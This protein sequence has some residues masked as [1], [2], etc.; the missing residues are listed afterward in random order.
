MARC[1]TRR[2]KNKKK[3]RHKGTIRPEKKPHSFLH[4]R[5]RQI[6][7]SFL[8][9]D[10]ATAWCPP[11]DDE[12]RFFESAKKL[13]DY[14]SMTWDEIKTRDHSIALSKLV[15]QAQSRLHELKLDDFDELWRLQFDG[16][17]RLWGLRVEDDWFFALWWDP[18]H[19]VCPS[20]QKHT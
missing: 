13:R 19:K 6:R 14:E 20:V 15:R 9:F 12:A 1:M 11:E 5:Q 10:G 4:S 18:L 8:R 7:I 3:P 2:Q 17:K 16:L